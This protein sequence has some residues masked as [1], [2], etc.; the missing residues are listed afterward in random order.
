MHLGS[1][2]SNAVPDRQLQQLL[3]VVLLGLGIYYSI[4]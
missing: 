2:V 3:I 1:K 4:G